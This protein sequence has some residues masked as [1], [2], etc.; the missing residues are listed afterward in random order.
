MLVTKNFGW[1][2][3]IRPHQIYGDNEF[4]LYQG[5]KLNDETDTAV[6]RVDGKNTAQISSFKTHLRVERGRFLSDVENK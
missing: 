4:D 1:K 2:C 3:W 5:F 6:L